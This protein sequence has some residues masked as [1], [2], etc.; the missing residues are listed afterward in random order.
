[1]DKKYNGFNNGRD[2]SDGVGGREVNNGTQETMTK[3]QTAVEW[4]AD[5]FRQYQKE[6]YRSNWDEVIQTVLLAKEIED[7]ELAKE[8]EKAKKLVEAL[9]EIADM[10]G[11]ILIYKKA[12]QSLTEYRT[13]PETTGNQTAC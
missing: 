5:R 6:G 7:K 2:K 12:K 8:R 9:E 4:I 1:M 13:L 10:T 3:E 11:N